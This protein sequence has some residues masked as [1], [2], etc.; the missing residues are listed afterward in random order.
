MSKRLFIIPWLLCLIEQ[1]CCAAAA[2]KIVFSGE[3]SHA[4]CD[5]LT[6]QNMDPACQAL[7]HNS[8]I[9]LLLDPHL[10]TPNNHPD[11]NLFASFVEQHTQ[12]AQISLEP[13]A[14][15]TNL[16]RILLSYK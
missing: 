3:I 11:P 10:A 13:I 6:A 12:F 4:T 1:P 9:D 16:G 2:A 7:A 14:N 5:L 15:A 8:Q